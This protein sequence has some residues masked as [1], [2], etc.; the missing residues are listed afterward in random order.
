MCSDSGTKTLETVRSLKDSETAIQLSLPRSSCR[1]LPKACSERVTQ[2][3]LRTRSEVI[4]SSLNL[5]VQAYLFTEILY[6]TFP[7]AMEIGPRTSSAMLLPH[8]TVKISSSQSE[9]GSLR[10]PLSEN[11][12]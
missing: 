9:K 3:S 11:N 1:S 2:F 10:L 12:S 7:G 6:S 4:C 8:S 5:L